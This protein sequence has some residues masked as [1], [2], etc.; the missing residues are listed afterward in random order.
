[1]N[2]VLKPRQ[3]AN[4]VIV[5]RPH[6]FKFNSETA[7]DNLF[8]N[9]VDMEN[10]ENFKDKVMHE[11][12]RCVTS[13]REVGL[14]VSILDDIHP[15][16]EEL[17]DSLFPN[18]WFSTDCFG[19]IKVFPMLA[20]NRQAEVRP[21]YLRT[22]LESEGFIVNEIIDYRIQLNGI[23]EG[24]GSIVKDHTNSTIYASLSSRCE[25]EALRSF[26]ELSPWNIGCCFETSDRR[27]YPI[28]HTNVVLSLGDKFAVLCDQA[29]PDLEDRK[30]LI[31]RLSKHREV[32]LISMKQME[33][34]CGNILEVESLT[35]ESLVL[36]S[37]RAFENFND[38]QLV[39]LQ[40]FARIV[41]IPIPTIEDVGGG[42]IRC[43]LA[44]NFLP[45]NV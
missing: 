39:S 23:L 41:A 42:S 34:F 22:L 15:P 24:T 8:Q 14:H 43:M 36:M 29:I 9:I 28:Y 7:G 12:N 13:L 33:Q 3:C 16:V 31:E 32:I 40:K 6:Y 25:W 21:E 5:A 17:I 2:S 10:S 38:N 30:I 26:K 44:E 35:G 27:G 4:S 37:K 20:S 1:M 19:V 11:F 45:R 18:N